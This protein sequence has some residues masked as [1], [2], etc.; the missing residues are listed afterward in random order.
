[1]VKPQKYIYCK[2][3]DSR[4]RVKPKNLLS[5]HAMTTQGM[6]P[7]RKQPQSTHGEFEGCGHYAKLSADN[8]SSLVAVVFK[9]RALMP[10]FE[11]PAL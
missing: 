10:L 11:R 3:P 9:Q 7:I 2:I 8:F 5:F 4:K 1:M 6:V